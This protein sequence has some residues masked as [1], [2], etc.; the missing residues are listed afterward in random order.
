LDRLENEISHLGV[1]KLLGQKF[2]AESAEAKRIDTRQGNCVLATAGMELESGLNKAFEMAAEYR[3]V[4]P[5][6]V[7]IDRDFDFYRLLGQDVSVL[8]GLEQNG[9]ITTELFHQILSQ[10]EWIPE[11]VNLKDL[12]ATVKKLKDNAQKFLMEQ[13]NAALNAATGRQPLPA[14][15]TQ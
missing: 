13:R 7:V 8:G 14:S 1:T 2:V 5:P 6:K 12:S 3:G 4:E 9:Q 10:G 15:S 11:D